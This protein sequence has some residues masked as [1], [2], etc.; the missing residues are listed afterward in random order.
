MMH[1]PGRCQRPG[2]L[3]ERRDLELSATSLRAMYAV[4]ALIPLA[5]LA[6]FWMLIVPSSSE[7]PAPLTLGFVIYGLPPCV[8]VPISGWGVWQDFTVSMYFMMSS[9]ALTL[10]G[11]GLQYFVLY[12]AKL[13]AQSSLSWL[14]LFWQLASFVVFAAI[15]ARTS[16]ARMA[17]M[18]R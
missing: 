15:A 4:A 2:Q 17:T 7:L 9:V 16:N 18:K 11:F 3:T 1:C 10:L 13:D 8:Y 6:T 14:L 5:G 12:V